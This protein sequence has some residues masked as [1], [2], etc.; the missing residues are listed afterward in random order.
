MALFYQVG[1]FKRVNTIHPTINS[2]TL[3]TLYTM[4]MLF[5]LLFLVGCIGLKKLKSMYIVCLVLN[6]PCNYNPLSLWVFS[7]L[8]RALQGIGLT[9][10][11]EY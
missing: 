3:Y 10:T 9:S 1:H 5:C 8:I 7:G 4:N 6:P 2:L 11:P